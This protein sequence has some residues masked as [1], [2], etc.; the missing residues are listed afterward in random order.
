MRTQQPQKGH[1]PHLN[2]LELDSNAL[3]LLDGPVLGFRQLVGQGHILKFQVLQEARLGH[4]SNLQ[5]ERLQGR[6]LLD[7]KPKCRLARP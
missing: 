3:L 4:L 5:R 1:G 6:K 7:F 2:A